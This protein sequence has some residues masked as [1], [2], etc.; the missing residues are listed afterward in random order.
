MPS[1]NRSIV[2]AGL[3]H[4]ANDDGVEFG[5]CI[6]AKMEQVARLFGGGRMKTPSTVSAIPKDTALQIWAEIRGGFRKSQHGRQ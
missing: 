1:Y 4:F 6:N 5:Y 2:V 3:Y